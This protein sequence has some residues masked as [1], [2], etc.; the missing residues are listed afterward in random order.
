LVWLWAVFAFASELSNR[1]RAL[2]LLAN[3]DVLFAEGNYEAAMLAYREVLSL[4]GESAMHF[5]IA[6]CL[7]LLGELE[8]AYE[9]LNLYRATAPPEEQQTLDRRLTSIRT[10]IDATKP[11]PDIPTGELGESRVELQPATVVLLGSG[12]GLGL[13]SLTGVGLS[14]RGSRRHQEQNNR[15]AYAVDR[16]VNAVSWLGL[17]VGAG[18]ALT[19][20]VIAG[21]VDRAPAV[22]VVLHPRS[23][24]VQGHF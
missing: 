24:V 21:P 23:L 11:V 19:G 1:G 9:E 3:G 12:A 13:V 22:S 4:S 8:G 18:L 7:E 14:Y 15:E 17:G 16:G 5:N 2:E 20:V 10:R 6:N